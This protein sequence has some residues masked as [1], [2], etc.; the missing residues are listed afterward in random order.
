MVLVGMTKNADIHLTIYTC[1]CALS[2][3]VDI[4][5]LGEE[6]N[7]TVV[8]SLENIQF[9]SSRDRGQGIFLE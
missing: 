6:G 5:G 2:N 8:Y 9:R 4:R 7:L 1:S 3:T